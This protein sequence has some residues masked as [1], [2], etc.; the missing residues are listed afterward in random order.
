MYEKLVYRDPD[1]GKGRAAAWL[2]DLRNESGVYVLKGKYSEKILYVGESHSGRLALTIK[3]HFW[4]WNDQTERFHFIINMDQVLVGV[5][6][7]RASAAKM[8]QDEYIKNL[9]PAYNKFG[10]SPVLLDPFPDE[11]TF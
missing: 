4:A 6:T 7:C 11:K 9:K 1:N 8:M 10:A 3:R 5:R 2:N